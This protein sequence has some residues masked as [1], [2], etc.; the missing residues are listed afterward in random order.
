MASITMSERRTAGRVVEIAAIVIAAILVAHI[1]FV[2][3]GAN[4]GND[5]VHTIGDWAKWFAT[6]FQ[7]LF[8]PS[9]YKVATTLNYGLAAICYLVA[10]RLIA[11]ILNKA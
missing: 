5:I 4:S 6:W 1:V 9:S 2:L 3:L 8:T 10:G 7:D 11:T